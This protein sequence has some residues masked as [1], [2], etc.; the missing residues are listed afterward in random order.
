VAFAPDLYHGNVADTIAGAE[1][2]GKALDANPL[3]ARAEIAQ[4]AKFLEERAG[5]PGRGLAWERTRAF[6]NR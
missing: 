4:A 1:T 3:Q 2:L 5:Q 6:L